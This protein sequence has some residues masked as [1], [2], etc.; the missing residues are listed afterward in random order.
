MKQILSKLYTEEELLLFLPSIHP[1]VGYIPLLYNFRLFRGVL[2][3]WQECEMK[4]FQNV[5]LI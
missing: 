1:K 5:S 2:N 3:V 4:P